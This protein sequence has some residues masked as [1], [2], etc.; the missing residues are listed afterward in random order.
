MGGDRIVFVVA[1]VAAAAV[2]AAVA[3]VD[4]VVGLNAEMGQDQ[5]W[6]HLFALIVQDDDNPHY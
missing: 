6:H 3:V 2:V 1:V 5:R 4:T